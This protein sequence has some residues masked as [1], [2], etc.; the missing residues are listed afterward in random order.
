MRKELQVVSLE[1]SLAEKR[2][3]RH[4]HESSPAPESPNQQNAEMKDL[5]QKYESVI[6]DYEERMLEL[7]RAHANQCEQLCREVVEAN[8][9]VQL[10]QQTL[11][12]VPPTSITT[13]SKAIPR[14]RRKGIFKIILAMGVCAVAALIMAGN[15]DNPVEPLHA[16]TGRF[17]SY[18]ETTT[19]HFVDR[20]EVSEPGNKSSGQPRRDK[21]AH[22]AKRD[23]LGRVAS[24]L[25][26]LRKVILEATAPLQWPHKDS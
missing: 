8:Q 2:L 25:R 4:N 15:L 14:R 10:M 20:T 9:E 1:K 21:K 12:G 5:V 17:S 22:T 23:K 26:F 16:M 7:N 19:H 11:A 24:F 3:E 18:V 13:S 6:A